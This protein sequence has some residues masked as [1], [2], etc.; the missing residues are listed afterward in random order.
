MNRITKFINNI[1]EALA[2]LGELVKDENFK[3]EMLMEAGMKEKQDA[4]SKAKT[5]EKLNFVL[6]KLDALRKK[7]GLDKTDVPNVSNIVGLAIVLQEL[8]LVWKAIHEMLKTCDIIGNE[9]QQHTPGGRGDGRS[10]C[11]QGYFRIS[12]ANIIKEKI[13]PGSCSF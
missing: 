9:D 3:G 13:T 10:Q 7:L 5:K 6:E 8:F 4:A 2:P 12:F 11:P 1:D